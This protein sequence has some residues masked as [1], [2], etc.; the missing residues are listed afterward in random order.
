MSKKRKTPDDDDGG[1]GSGGGG[2]LARAEDFPCSSCADQG[3]QS[4]TLP[5]G[6]T[7][8]FDR[9]PVTAGD[10]LKHENVLKTQVM[11]KIV[12]ACR[13]KLHMD[14]ATRSM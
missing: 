3:M 13:C 1:G 10:V 6:L 11:L 7:Q 4:R 9:E 14:R 5:G 8:T 2:E 12:R